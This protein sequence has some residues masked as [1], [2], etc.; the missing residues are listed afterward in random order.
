MH[1]IIKIY[2]IVYLHK[3]QWNKVWKQLR[4]TKREENMPFSNFTEENIILHLL[5]GR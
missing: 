1:I 5:L 3:I 4:T 2:K